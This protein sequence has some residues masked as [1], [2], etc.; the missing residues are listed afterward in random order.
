M[1]SSSQLLKDYE[2]YTSGQ[3]SYQ[4]IQKGLASK[5]GLDEKRKSLENISK[6][7]IDTEKL[8]EQ[9]PEAVQLRARQLG[10]PTTAAQL[11]KLSTVQQAPITKQIGELSRAEQT[12]QVGL[13]DIQNQILQEL[14]LIKETRGTEREDWWNKINQAF[15]LESQARE[16]QRQKELVRM[17][18][19]TAINWSKLAESLKTILGGGTTTTNPVL[20]SQIGS[21][22]GQVGGKIAGTGGKVGWG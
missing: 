9:V 12:G 20:P 18:Q 8:L 6:T 19:Q 5:L 11:S 1:T 16:A 21:A 22:V 7:I 4:D 14:G 3:Q 13:S 15:T 2:T 17:Q 10:G